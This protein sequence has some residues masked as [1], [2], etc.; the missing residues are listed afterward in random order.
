MPRASDDTQV[1]PRVEAEPCVVKHREIRSHRRRRR[2]RRIALILVAVLGL[3]GG[4]AL[5]SSWLYV[6]SVEASIERVD[7]FDQVP[8]ESRPM[9]V[10]PSALNMLVLGSDSGDPDPDD[11]GA[12]TD[13]IMLVHIPA[14]RS[15]AQLISIPRDTWLP[16]PKSADGRHGGED[17]KINQSYEWGGVPLLIQTVESFTKVRID[18]VGILEFAGFVRIIDAIGGIDITVDRNFKSIHP[19]FRQFH[20]GRQHMDGA[21]ALDY[22]RQRKQWPDGDFARIRHQQAVIKAML[23]KAASSGLLTNPAQLNAFVRATADAVTVD[24]TMS[25]VDMAMNLRN[26][27]SNNITFLTSPVSS[28]GPVGSQSV[29]FADFTKASQLY[30]AVRRDSVAEIVATA[31]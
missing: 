13:T 26:L 22:S 9:K 29:V 19:P 4:G 1:L 18:H 15:S 27:R 10:V 21:T 23:D 3:V 11:D 2:V 31:K 7:A 30:D 14:D 6:R 25:I 28:T 17:G 5:I 16:I 8:D 24:R 20:K 12:R